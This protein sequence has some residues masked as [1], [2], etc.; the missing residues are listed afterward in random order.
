MEQDDQV[1]KMSMFRRLMTRWRTRFVTPQGKCWIALKQGSSKILEG[2]VFGAGCRP[3]AL[4]RKHAIAH[5]F[6]LPHK[7]R[8]STLNIRELHASHFQDH[9]LSAAHCSAVRWHEGQVAEGEHAS[10]PPREAF[11]KVVA[12]VAEYG[13]A[14]SEAGVPG[15]G[16]GEKCRKLLLCYHEGMRRLDM[17]W[18]KGMKS[19]TV[20]RDSRQGKLLLRYVAVNHDLRVRRGILGQTKCEA[21]A[22]AKLEGTKRLYRR[23]ATKNACLGA[24]KNGRHNIRKIFVKPM[25]ALLV[26]NTHRLVIDAAKDEVTASEMS[27]LLGMSPFTPNLREILRD[28]SHAATR[29]LSRPWQK[30][31]VLRDNTAFFIKGRA[32]PAQMVHHSKELRGWYKQELRQSTLGVRWCNL[33]AAKHRF[34]S[35]QK[36]TGRLVRGIRQM[37]ATMVRV[38]K[39]RND[40]RSKNATYWL[41][42]VVSRKLLLLGAQGDASDE[43]MAFLRFVDKESYDIAALSSRLANFLDRLYRYFGP[44]RQCLHKA[45][46]TKYVV[47]ELESTP[48]VFVCG[49]SVR[50][51][52]ACTDDDKDWVMKEMAAWVLLVKEIAVQEFP[53]FESAQCLH[54]FDF[55]DRGE[56]ARS[57]ADTVAIQRLSN[58]IGI[59]AADAAT[60]FDFLAAEAADRVAKNHDNEKSVRDAILWLEG[61]GL[62]NK[63]RQRATTTAV[64]PLCEFFIGFTNSTSGLEQTFTQS[65]RAWTSQQECASEEYEECVL[66]I[67]VD[68]HQYDEAQVVVAAQRI[69]AENFTAPRAS[70]ISKRADAG[71]TRKRAAESERSFIE[72]RRAPLPHRIAEESATYTSAVAAIEAMP[73]SAVDGAWT[74]AHDREKAF[75]R[76]KVQEKRLDA[77]RDG[78]LLTHEI[79]PALRAAAQTRASGMVKRHEGREVKR[80]RA[81]NLVHGGQRLN[82]ADYVGKALYGN[83]A[84]FDST[85]SE[86]ASCWRMVACTEISSAHLLV[87]KDPTAKSAASYEFWC[88]VLLGIPLVNEEVLRGKRGR[89]TVRY[90]PAL[91][92]KREVWLS[93]LFRRNHARITGLLEA[94]VARFGRESKW[95]LQ[96]DDDSWRAAFLAASAKA[97]GAASC[98]CVVTTSERKMLPA[99]L[100]HAYYGPELLKF[101]TH[102]DENSVSW[103]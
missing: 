74:E 65:E 100:R 80:A 18:M 17:N 48:I 5:N 11:K 52:E 83:G 31:R 53:F 72:A 78:L 34:A 67:L 10:A 50:A 26:D 57:E 30:C 89:I 75:Q 69:W 35:I 63:S 9:H 93:P 55:A 43:V 36:P 40:E 3:C 101:I 28:K 97:K 91:H 22:A 58:L 39:L 87:V 42:R 32:S 4:W 70:P 19:F 7:D 76:Q 73:V 66:K 41:S 94:C 2:N 24:F 38:S 47:D 23:F 95:K 62:T 13:A 27:R 25:H 61:A 98:V 68:G 71:R 14:F 6:A 90:T 15:A 51:L 33:S 60:Q 99:T 77:T 12:H 16:S 54:V 85:I 86:I 79:T 44:E 8:F 88:A 49:N 96:L 102:L 21:R 56:K 46:Y 92:T 20:M 84:E 29:F 45:G 64:R 81:E 1:A 82:H 59:N 103:Q 37:V